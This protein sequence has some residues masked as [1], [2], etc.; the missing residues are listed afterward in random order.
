MGLTFNL[1]RLS[2]SIF[3]DSSL[4]VGIGGSPSG[5]Y[6]LEVTGTLKTTGES[7]L[8]GNV[9]IGAA[10]ASL[11]Y[12]FSSTST[13]ELRL[14]RGGVGD[15]G[16]RWKRNSADLGYISNADWIIAGASSTDFAVNAVNNLVLGTASNARMTIT[17]AGNVGIG[18]STPNLTSVNRTT[19]DINGPIQSLLSFS[20]GGTALSYIFNDGYNFTLNTGSGYMNFQVNGSERMRITSG[21]NV[22]IG[23][24][25]DRS[26]K[27]VVE[28][29]DNNNLMGSYNTTSGSSL[30][31][32]SNQTINYIVSSGTNMLDFQ[33]N[34]AVRMRLIN[35]GNVSIGTTTDYGYKLNLDGQPGCNGYTAW[36][37][38]SDSRLKENITDLETTNVLDKICAIRPVTYN[39]NE[40]TGFDEATRSRRISGFIAQELMEVFPDM[41]GTIKKGD[42]E[43][44]D[45]NLSNLTLYLVK[46]IQEQQVQIQSLQA[47]NQDLKSRLDKAGL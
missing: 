9:G 15:V 30:R 35:G 41:V 46:A 10:A 32:Q 14:E 20:S 22:L 47:Q 17:S 8:T 33:V 44:Y 40:L 25:T 29:T 37:N 18:T 26:L 36:T 2:P 39:Y 1:G 28:G 27:L 4:N 13:A 24:S 11:L 38:W 42:E 7:L 6:K 16:M 3:T 43:Y 23:T 19:V 21:G 45:T 31:L 34:G 12:A 5:S